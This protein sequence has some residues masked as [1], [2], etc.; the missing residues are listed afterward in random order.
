MKAMCSCAGNKVV[1]TASRS[2]VRLPLVVTLVHQ[3]L[4][5]T[6]LSRL[7]PASMPVAQRSTTS[8]SRKRKKAAVGSG[9]SDQL[10]AKRAV[11]FLQQDPAELTSTEQNTV[12]MLCKMHP[13]VETIYQ[14]TQ[15]FMSM[16]KQQQAQFLGMRQN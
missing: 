10:L 15:G 16:L 1:T 13:R 7:R 2:G 8:P 14:L 5:T 9:P 4:S 11:R 6:S 12:Q 3:K